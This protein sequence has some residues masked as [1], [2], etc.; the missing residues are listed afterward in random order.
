MADTT[1]N[2]QNKMEKR[3]ISHDDISE[4]ISMTAA[5]VYCFAKGEISK[6]VAIDYIESNASIRKEFKEAIKLVIEELSSPEGSDYDID[7][8]YEESSPF[9][10]ILSIEKGR[11]FISMKF[12]FNDVDYIASLEEDVDCA[13]FLCERITGYEPDILVAMWD[14]KSEDVNFQKLMECVENVIAHLK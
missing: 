8:A 5:T 9:Y 11:G 4:I 12:S 2:T 10:N 1:K 7:K 6:N 3:T 14:V 13:T